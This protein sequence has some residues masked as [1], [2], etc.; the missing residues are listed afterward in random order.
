M[1]LSTIATV[2]QPKD[3][4]NDERYEQREP[5]KHDPL[6]VESAETA[7]CMCHRQAYEK[8]ESRGND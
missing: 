4:K 7:G 8:D 1:I 3:R 6:T 5:Q 2:H